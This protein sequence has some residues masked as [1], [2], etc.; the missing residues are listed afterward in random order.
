MNP[1]PM[2]PNEVARYH[3]VPQAIPRQPPSYFV[4][5]GID[6]HRGSDDLDDYE[7][8]ELSLDG[9]VRFALLRDR[10]APGGETTIFLPDQYHLEI[11]PDIVRMITDAL[12]LTDSAITWRRRAASAPY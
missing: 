8:A 5:K 2:S 11:V 4:S 9:G 6:F 10:G 12:D 3:F 7:V 1:C